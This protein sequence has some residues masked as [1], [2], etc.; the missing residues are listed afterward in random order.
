M[1]NQVT[2]IGRLGSDP[3]IRVTKTGNK[4]CNLGLATNKKIKVKDSD[5]YQEKTQ[6]HSITV[7]QPA[8]V[9]SL[10]KYAKKGSTLFVQGSLE[11]RE[12][13]VDGK[14]RY[15]TNIVCAG[16]EGITRILNSGTNGKSAPNSAGSKTSKEEEID[17][18]F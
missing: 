2:L 7:F 8:L 13:E 10:E 14:K 16:Y 6:W 18:P 1:I 4:F 15:A 5:E 9:D 11:Y 12:Y 3:E 17:V